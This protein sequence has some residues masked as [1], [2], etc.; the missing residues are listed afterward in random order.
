MGGG[1]KGR[2]EAC[3]EGVGGLNK[4]EKETYGW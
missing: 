1:A 2:S 3:G 4:E